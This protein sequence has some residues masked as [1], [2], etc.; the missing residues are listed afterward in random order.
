MNKTTLEKWLDV[1]CYWCDCVDEYAERY[2][3]TAQMAD[4]YSK[5]IDELYSI[6]KGL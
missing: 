5:I 6:I 3:D 4:K 2:P 1:L